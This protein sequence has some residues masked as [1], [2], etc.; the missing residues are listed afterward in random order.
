M[1]GDY[2]K[3]YHSMQKIGQHLPGTNTVFALYV[4]TAINRQKY[5]ITIIKRSKYECTMDQEL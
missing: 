1:L 5:S 2:I 4:K 3:Q